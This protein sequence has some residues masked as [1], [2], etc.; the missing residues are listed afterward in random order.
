MSSPLETYKIYVD[1]LKGYLD[2]ALMANIWFYAITGA[3]V[4]NYLT[5]GKDKQ[6]LRFSLI[7]PAILGVALA[8]VSFT[9]LWYAW[10]LRDKVHEMAVSLK[11]KGAP[12]V[13]ILSLFLLITGA[14]SLVVGVSLAVLVFWRPQFMFNDIKR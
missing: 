10:N 1:I 2:T 7:I 9:G 12:P 11:I 6:F 14:V 4:A 13:G 5:N 3:I 8:F